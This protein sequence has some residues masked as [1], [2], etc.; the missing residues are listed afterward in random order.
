MQE[1]PL[2]LISADQADQLIDK[3]RVF[4]V[5]NFICLVG[6]GCQA[7]SNCGNVLLQS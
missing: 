1:Y 7:K 5:L 6:V 4:G 2:Q 3:E